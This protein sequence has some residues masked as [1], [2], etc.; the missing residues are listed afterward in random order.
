M[1]PTAAIG[2]SAV[3]STNRS[4]I[5]RTVV[6]EGPGVPWET[7]RQVCKE[8]LAAAGVF[9]AILARAEAF[10]DP[11]AL[12]DRDRQRAMRFRCL[13][14]RDNFILGR[15]LV[16]RLIQPNAATSPC[17]VS[18]G[19]HGKPYI[20]G[21]WAFNVSHSSRWVACAVA[22]TEPIG[23]D[24]EAFERLDDYRGVLRMISHEAEQRWIEQAP[25]EYREALFKRCWTRKEA[26]LKATG[27]GLTDDLQAIDVRLHQEE[28]V[29]K[30]PA[31]L[32]LISLDEC[33]PSI[34]ASLAVAVS[35][36]EVIVMRIDGEA[37]KSGG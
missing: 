1:T 32:R 11:A 34:T 7:V 6:E 2:S 37:R 9:V 21:A 14:H 35:V 19:N 31:L 4:G 16:Q 20:P 24:I 25:S 18:I 36:R 28:P 10:A 26:V 30:H 15:T 33:D 3:L 12:S 13:I 8:T 17:V 27:V 29:L 23:L 5:R 22:R